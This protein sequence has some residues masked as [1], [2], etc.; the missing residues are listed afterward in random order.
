M[1]A[2][3][4]VYISL[5][6]T[7][8]SIRIALAHLSPEVVVVWRFLLA[9]LFLLPLGVGLGLISTRNSSALKPLDWSARRLMWNGWIGCLVFVIGNGV[10][11]YPLQ[12]ISSG[13]A[14]GI[15][16]FS[17]FFM[18]ALSRWIP[19]TE[20]FSRPVFQALLVGLCGI[21]LMIG[22]YQSAQQSQVQS[23][24]MLVYPLWIQW[25]S[26]GLM[27][28]VNIC[29]VSGS[30]MIRQQRQ[31]FPQLCVDTALQCLTAVIVFAGVSL[32]KGHSLNVMTY[33]VSAVGA[34]MYLAWVGTCMGMLCY[35]Y[36]L[37]TLPLA[38]TGSFAYVTPM[39][40]MV[41]GVA[42]L[43]EPASPLMWV[44]MLF[45]LASVIL[46]HRVTLSRNV[47]VIEKQEVAVS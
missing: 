4:V 9:A 24:V 32:F 38:L 33:P 43:N 45:I 46:I 22:G 30:L 27:M 21:V 25:A 35:F 26:M 41:L 28:L 8:G 18:V 17:P 15:I 6:T 34:L 47:S 42:F 7:F 37:K 12:Y 11:C 5:S 14:A 13:M 10:L 31:T 1:V 3:V 20:P 29:W 39:L 36:V 23:Q 19:P 2:L 44:G 16:A 40:T